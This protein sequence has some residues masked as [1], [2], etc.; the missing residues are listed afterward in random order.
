MLMALCGDGA[1]EAI[2]TLELQPYGKSAGIRILLCSGGLCASAMSG[3]VGV[4][5][6]NSD[7]DIGSMFVAVEIL[8]SSFPTVTNRT[9]FA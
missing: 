1:R 9:E 4:C 8:R 6:E 2:S 3:V 5:L 7:G